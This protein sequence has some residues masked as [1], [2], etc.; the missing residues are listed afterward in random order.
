VAKSIQKQVGETRAP[1]VHIVYEVEENGAI[2]K[3]EIP[4][5]VGVMG[6][7][8]G[9]P[10]QEQPQ[11]KDRKF[12]RIDKDNFDNVMAKMSPGLKTK[13]PNTLADD[14]TEIPVELKFDSMED[15]EPGNLINQIEPLKKLA[16]MRNKLRDL[17]AKADGRH[18]LETMLEDVLQNTEAVG[19][20]ADEL[21]IKKEGE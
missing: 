14:D 2:V 15:F 12:V 11:L 8:S 9:D 20:L 21:G 7:F 4:F 16:D 17:L 3:K 19:K 5:V 6:D 10:T 18:E 13:V 1:R